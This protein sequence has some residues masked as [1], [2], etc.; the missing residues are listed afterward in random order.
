M[1]VRLKDIEDLTG[2]SD[3]RT[4]AGNINELLDIQHDLSRIIIDRITYR[5]ILYYIGEQYVE[6]VKTA[7]TFR[8]RLV[9]AYIPTPVDNQIRDYVI[10]AKAMLLNQRLVPK[11]SPNT[12]EAEDIKA[13]QM[14]SKVLEWMDTINDNEFADEKEKLVIWLCLAG[15]AFLRTY[16]DMSMGK[17]LL[18]N[19]KSG[20]V[21][22]RAV[23]PFSVRFEMSGE[24]LREKRWVGLQ[25]LYPRE[26]IED[27]FKVKLEGTTQPDLIDYERKLMK[28]VS[29]VSPWKGAGLETQMY[30][31][32]LDQVLIREVEFRPTQK[33]SKGRYIVNCEQEILLD[34]D[35]LPIKS[36]DE[37]FYY[38]LT[39]FH[40]H[41]VPGRFWADAP[42]NDLISP[43]NSINEIDQALAM[44]RKGLGRPRVICPGDVKFK[45]VQ[46]GAHNFLILSYDALLSGNKEP[47]IEPGTPYPTQV[48]EERA[49]KVTSIQD[50]TGD[51]KNIL[52]GRAPSAQSSGVQIDILRETAERGHYPDVDRF[53]RSM[54]RAYK[55]RLVLAQEIYTEKR[56]I[57]IAGRGRQVEIFSFRAADLRKNTD[58]RLEIDSGISTTRAGQTQILMQMADKGYLGPITENP[59]LRQE[60]LQRMGLSGATTQSN[61]DIERAEMENAAISTGKPFDIFLADATQPG[62]DG[63]P[64]VTNLD[65][66]FKYDDHAVHYAVH[67]RFI[68]SNAFAELPRKDQ[69]LMFVHTDMHEMELMKRMAMMAQQAQQKQGG[70]GRGIQEGGP[71][72]RKTPMGEELPLRESEIV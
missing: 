25:S 61:V 18:T 34:V 27:I 7:G 64:T 17:W 38:T 59:E 60:F 72:P 5:N 3:T 70:D 44:N 24:R 67:R 52:K 50:M 55:K 32:D 4:L 41:Y 46:E 62:P 37:S 56:Q 57:K 63:S 23:I 28:L 26:Y 36:E 14:G 10:A 31:E 15:T 30:Q 12:N 65:P 43:Q 1:T 53:N 13:S 54:E 19:Q 29:Q 6:F 40:F 9:P 66:L 22:T 11:V 8:R 49:I 16:P 48:L 33:F 35:R 45:R 68:L 21:I 58:V 42:V 51:P 69:T 20:E 39:D 2:K 71:Q 47:K